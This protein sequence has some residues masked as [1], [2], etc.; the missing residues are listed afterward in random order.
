VTDTE[1][2]LRAREHHRPIISLSTAGLNCMAAALAYDSIMGKIFT[3]RVDP[4]L[5]AILR[6][7]A[8]A[9]GVSVSRLVRDACRARLHLVSADIDRRQFNRFPLANSPEV[10]R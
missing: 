9:N 6:D 7:A 5:A 2:Q 4:D 1:A 8:N 3:F 10:A